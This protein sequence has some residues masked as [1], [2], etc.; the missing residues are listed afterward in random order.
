[1]LCFRRGSQTD[2]SLP[3]IYF[4]QFSPSFFK[5]YSPQQT[6]CGVFWWG[7]RGGGAGPIKKLHSSGGKDFVS[8][9]D[10]YNVCNSVLKRNK[11][12]ESL[13]WP[14]IWLFSL[15]LSCHWLSLE[16][17]QLLLCPI[18]AE[19]TSLHP[20]SIY[21]SLFQASFCFFQWVLVF[22]LGSWIRQKV[23]LESSSSMSY[24]STNYASEK[25]K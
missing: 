24:D 25:H 15:H 2:L 3:L 4:N 22:C 10:S 13:Q 17:I 8:C 16:Q 7:E 14:N 1:M 18:S 20:A 9:L 12:F 21:L 23:P 5:S 6:F 11:T 19:I